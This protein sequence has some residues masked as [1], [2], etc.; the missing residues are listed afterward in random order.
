MKPVG[1]M[2]YAEIAAWVCSFLNTHNI[3]AV[4]SGGG[5]VSIYTHNRYQ[6]MDLDFV[7]NVSSSRRKV[8]QVLSQIGFKEEN[9]YY[10]HPETEMIIE[11]P[12]GPLAVGNEPVREIHELSFSTGIL[13]LLSPTDCVKDRLSAFYHWDDKQALEQAVL[14][15]QSQDVDYDEVERWSKAEGRHDRFEHYQSLLPDRVAGE[16]DSGEE[17]Q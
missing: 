14:V 6:S 9:R 8:K 17:P 3:N 5:V 12:P 1:E 4:L 7:E 10:R 13:K 16:S 15:S 11:L 2:E